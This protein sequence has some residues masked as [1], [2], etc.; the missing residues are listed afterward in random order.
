[1]VRQC[2]CSELEECR[3]QHRQQMAMCAL[4]CQANLQPSM[5]D[6]GQ[7]VVQCMMELRGD[8]EE[9][10]CFSSLRNRVCTNI[11]GTM[12]PQQ[13]E[14]FGGMGRRFGGMG[15]QFGGMGGQFGGMGGRFGGMG[16]GGFLQRF[17]QRWG[18]GNQQSHPF[19]TCM[20]ECRQR[21]SGGQHM[22]HHMACARQRGCS[23]LRPPPMEFFQTFRSCRPQMMEK[24]QRFCDCLNR[25]GQPGL[26]QAIQSRFG[27]GLMG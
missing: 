21:V 7:A 19:L 1:M 5:I 6:R 26:C 24:K 20:K 25:N 27:L 16:G 23:I 11:P 17:R 2:L 22:P 14:G 3:Q 18:G 15:G 12:I 13:P 10:G 4:E 8:G 9:G